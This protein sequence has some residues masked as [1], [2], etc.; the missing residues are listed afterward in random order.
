MQHSPRSRLSG[1][2]TG[3]NSSTPKRRQFF[4]TNQ[5][6]PEPGVTRLYVDNSGPIVSSTLEAERSVVLA[7]LLQRRGAQKGVELGVQRGRFAQMLLS[8]WACVNSYLLVDVWGPLKN[9]HD[10]ANVDQGNQ[11]QIYEEAIRN[12]RQW[13]VSVCRNS[14]LMCS[15]IHKD[16]TF[17]FIYVDARHDYQGVTQDLESWFPRLISGGIIA[18][19][20][21]LTATEQSPLNHKSH[22][23]VNM[24]GS[25]DITKRAVLGAVDDF[26]GL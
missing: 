26:F 25:L 6:H 17:D 10:G 18:G 21:Y 8:K 23:E 4:K 12:T 22:W 7:D 15:Q 19:H 16:E 14:T 20:D 1:Q 3:L 9:Y 5:V 24:D 13:N 2:I 11:N